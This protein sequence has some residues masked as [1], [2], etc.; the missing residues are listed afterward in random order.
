[1]DRNVEEMRLVPYFDKDRSLSGNGFQ[2][3]R[4]RLRKHGNMSTYLKIMKNP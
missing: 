4:E 3:G 1:M 2:N